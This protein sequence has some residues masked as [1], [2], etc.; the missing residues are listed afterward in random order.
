MSALVLNGV[1]W[2]MG[3][4]WNHPTF[5]EIRQ[6][7]IVPPASW[8][9]R[10]TPPPGA[11]T[12]AEP[13][14][15]TD[16]GRVVLIFNAPAHASVDASIA[17]QPSVPTS[18]IPEYPAD[19]SSNSANLSVDSPPSVLRSYTGTYVSNS[20]ER[21]RV[22]VTVDG[23]RLQLEVV[24]AFRSPLATLPKSQLLACGGG[25]CRVAFS[26]SAGGTVD[27]IEIQYAGREIEA[28]RAQGAV[29]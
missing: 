12:S 28:F 23:G 20:A 29:F 10:T 6:P 18:T 11:T 1:C 8:K 7:V 25:D 14:L 26:S 9:V 19:P 27:R 17:D 22:I 5:M 3:Y 24:G 21:E 16:E 15:Y 13:G 2:T 4:A